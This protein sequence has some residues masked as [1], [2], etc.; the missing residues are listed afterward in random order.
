MTVTAPSG[1]R[2]H[3]EFAAR[4]GFRGFRD[5]GIGCR[6]EILDTLL[7]DRARSAGVRVLQRAKVEDVLRSARGEVTGVRVRVD[8]GS[9]SELH[10][11]MVIGADGLRST[12]AH[13]LALARRSRWPRRLAIMTHF[14]GVEGMTHSGE[15]HVSRGGYLGLAQVGANVTN[16]AL[17][18]PARTFSAHS[19]RGDSP[20]AMLQRWIAEHPALAPRFAHA[21]NL[22]PVRVTGPFASRARRA[23]A[24][25]AVL[26]GDAADFHDPFTGEGI[27]A[28]LRGGELAAP[29]V[30]R[31][32]RALERGKA[33]DAR[34]AL[35]DYERARRCTF[36]GKWRVERLIGLA[37]ATPWLMN[38][39]AGILANNRDLADLLVGVTGD[40]VPPSMLLQPK[41]LGRLLA[42]G[43]LL[44]SAPLSVTLDA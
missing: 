39:A 28:A 21:E 26:V 38:R 18:I 41:M 17:V 34:A 6:R 10:A 29:F 42:P 7:L 25:G 3:G 43:R 27:Y 19:A 44:S 16:V 31:S 35:A 32:L 24:P 36:G 12:V 23:W 8:D 15:M 40:F 13:R 14:G 4:H 5:R 33:R 20:M 11:L 22:S 1:T 2:F 37:V 9:T 30:A